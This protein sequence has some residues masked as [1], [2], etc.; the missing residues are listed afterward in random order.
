MFIFLNSVIS[1]SGDIDRSYG[2]NREYRRIVKPETVFSAIHCINLLNKA[3]SGTLP[4]GK[5]PLL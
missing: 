5:A 1:A 4:D 3:K 2:I